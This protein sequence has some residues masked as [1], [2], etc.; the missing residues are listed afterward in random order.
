M[1][2]WLPSLKWPD[3]S[4]R[5]RMYGMHDGTALLPEGLGENKG[6]SICQPWSAMQPSH[7]GSPIPLAPFPTSFC[8][9]GWSLLSWACLL[10]GT[11]AKDTLG[12]P[13]GRNKREL[14]MCTLET[15]PILS[16]GQSLVQS[17]TSSF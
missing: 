12:L 13:V 10:R 16:R 5:S 14:L 6:V 1:A 15:L 7:P 11:Q 3:G 9:W 8:L 17:I 2:A 4:V